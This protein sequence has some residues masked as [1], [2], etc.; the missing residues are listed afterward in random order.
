MP[1]WTPKQHRR[2]RWIGGVLVVAGITLNLYAGVLAAFQMGRSCKEFGLTVP[3]WN[4]RQA[5]CYGLVIMV[6]CGVAVSR[7]ASIV[8]RAEGAA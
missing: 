4:C 1:T 2:A 8:V 7:R 3:D 6:V 5:S